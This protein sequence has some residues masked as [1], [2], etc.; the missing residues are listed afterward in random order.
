MSKRISDGQEVQLYYI[1]CDISKICKNYFYERKYL[2][3]DAWSIDDVINKISS[4]TKLLKNK[5]SEIKNNNKK[6]NYE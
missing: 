4:S 1:I 5:Y 2:P 6:Q 3:S